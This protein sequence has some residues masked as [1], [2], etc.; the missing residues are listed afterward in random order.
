M[1]RHR[2]TTIM[3]VA[4]VLALVASPVSA[5][6]PENCLWCHR[7]RGLSRVDPETG[8]LHLFFCSAEYYAGQEGPHSRLRCTACHVRQEVAV[9]PHRVKT[10]VDCARQ[11]H[12]VPSAG[13]ELPFSHRSIQERL[14]NSAHAPAKLANLPFDPRLLRPRQ[15]ACLYCHDQPVFRKS[16]GMLARGDAGVGNVRCTTCHT[17]ELPV[18]VPYHIRHV[19][20]RLQPA[21]PVRQLVQVCAVCHSDPAVLAQTEGHD[22]VASYLH[23]F[24]G[25]ASLLGSTETATCVDCHASESGDA[26]AML[27]KEDPLSSVHEARLPNTCRTTKCHPGAPPGM[28][29]AAVHLDLNPRAR[30]PEFYVAAL[31]IVLTAAVMIVFFIFIMLE[32]LNAVVR[33]RDP[34][35]ERLVRLAR[36]LSQMP[37]GRQLLERLTPHERVQHWVLAVTFVLLVVTGMPIKFADTAWASKLISL[38]GGLTLTRS[39][40]RLCGVTMMGAFVYHI[41]YLLIQFGRSVRSA[42]RR[43]SKQSIWRIM[44]RARPVMTWADVRAFGQLLAY[45]LFLRRE[46]PAFRH[47]NFMQKF[48]YWAVFWGVLLLGFSGLALWGAAGLSEHFSGRGLNFAFIIH[49]DEAYLAFIYIAVVHM[50]SVVLA[51]SVFPLSLG[52]LTGQAPAGEL[53]EGH[54]ATLES[55][56]RKLGVAVDDEP[57]AGRSF[58][59]GLKM[60]LRRTYSAGLLCVCATICFS[61]MHFLVTLLLTRQNAPIEIIQIPKRLDAGMLASSAWVPAGDG[62]G[63]KEPPRGPLA[64]FHQIPKWFQADPGNDCT[65]S[66]CHVSLPHGQRIEVRAFLNMHA[67]FLDCAVCHAA[68]TAEAQQQTGWFG[69]LDR[70]PRG[71]PAIL[72]L[73]SQLERWGQIAPED[74]PAVNEQIMRLLS[75]ALVD[76]GENIQL[77]HWL[78]RLETTHT[79]SEL[80][81]S[82]V[83]DIRRGIH[84]HNRGEYNAKIGLYA[85]RRQLGL[86]TDEQETTTAQYL[87]Q[88][89]SLS[90]RDRQPLLDIVHKG[91]VPQGALC[92]PCH[93]LAPTLVDFAVLGY[94]PSRVAALQSSKIVQQVLKIE[95]GQPFYLPRVLEF[96]DEH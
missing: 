28:S 93:S 61:S 94:S 48:E 83:D 14:E 63:A 37:Q 90:P 51:P 77:R 6:D 66:G 1:I 81:H 34:E 76:A 32:L 22:A 29:Q 57:L 59:Y 78:L 80:W 88:K 10:Y 43:G 45:L 55:V 65:T 15:S 42:R 46:R 87:A 11:C 79:Q 5:V 18:P 21:R 13:V 26:H 47:F 24:H 71:S 74:A 64:H 16:I 56:A 52:T 23:S 9:V 33:R 68:S 7:F 54:R 53:V 49:S 50:F 95:Q 12:V 85:G 36:R 30:T 72:R 31:F 92:V 89:D 70:E 44:A 69:L 20:S 41:A 82:I 35:H 91:V 60:L 84:L 62:A 38:M 19:T 17:E 67:T 73:A 75:A 4:W 58:R 2:T 3:C 96:G 40:H 86:L 39:I 27:S 25:K 8:E